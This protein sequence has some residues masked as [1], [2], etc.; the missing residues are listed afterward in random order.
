MDLTGQRFGRL[1]V[2][3]DCNSKLTTNGFLWECKCD[4]GRFVKTRTQNLKTGNTKSC[5][6][7]KI[8]SSGINAKSMINSENS[9]KFLLKD[10]VEIGTRITTLDPERKNSRNTSGFKGVSWSK[11]SKKWEV[12]ITFKGEKK[13]LGMFKNKQ[14]AINARKEAEEKYFKPIL[15]KY[16]KESN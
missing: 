6:C 4:C 11:R 8:A 9:K 16:S 2:T 1:V 14:D 12:Y 13:N 15:E 3:R 5:G 7:L 10:S